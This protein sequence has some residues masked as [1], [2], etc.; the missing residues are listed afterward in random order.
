[1]SKKLNLIVSIFLGLICTCL[2]FVIGIL[3]VINYSPNF[4]INLTFSTS[5]ATKIELAMNDGTFYV[6]YDT[7]PGASSIPAENVSST[8]TETNQSGVITANLITLGS[9]F[10]NIHSVDE[11]N[12]KVW[13]YNTDGTLA[14]NIN[15]V[16]NTQTDIIA[17]IKTPSTGLL[18]IPA[19]SV[20]N[21]SYSV[22]KFSVTVLKEVSM[23][24]N[25]DL[26]LTVAGS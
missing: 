2:M 22:L 14:A 11:F 15:A 25:L 18:G 4:T 8:Q 16:T 7:S 21:A 13:N 10:A 1:M 26:V 6:I 17:Q 9:N 23:Q 19:Y 5:M 12:F 3:A 24:L 20:P